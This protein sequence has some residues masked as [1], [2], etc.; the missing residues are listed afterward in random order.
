MKIVATNRKALRDYN[1]LERFECGIELKGAE[2]KS[3]RQSRIN[4]DDSFA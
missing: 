4:I 3:L 2:V 1:I